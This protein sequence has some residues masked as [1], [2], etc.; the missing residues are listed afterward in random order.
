MTITRN[1]L[2]IFKPELLGDSP[3]AGGQRTKNAVESGQ[4][5]E[6]FRAISDIDHSQSSVD[7]VKCYPALDTADTSVLLNGHIFI[8]QKPTDELVSMLIAESSDLDDADRMTDMVEILESSV[9][10]GQLIRNRLIG[11]LAGQDSFP[12]SY[13]QTIYQFNGKEYYETLTLQQ[14]QT[15]VISVEYEGNEDA[16]WPRFEHFC[17]VQETVSG[18]KGGAVRFKPEIPYDTPNYDVVI[19]GESGCTKLRYT[20]ENDGIKFHGVSALTAPSDSNEL[21][22]ENTVVELLPK[23]R[24][25]AVSGGNTLPGVEDNDNTASS[26]TEVLPSMVYK[27]IYVPSVAGQTT[28]IFE[29]PDLLKDTWLDDNGIQSVKYN[30]GYAQNASVN[31]VGTTVTVTFSGTA[32]SGNQSVGLSY[33]SVQKWGVWETPA[34]FPADHILVLGKA[35]GAI[36]FADGSYGTSEIRTQDYPRPTDVTAIPILETN[37]N[38][39]GTINAVT[40][41]VTKEPDFR[42]DFSIVLGSLLQKTEPGEVVTPGD[43]SVVF[44]LDSDSP[45]LDTLYIQV[46]TTNDV[47]LSASSDANGVITGNGITGSVDGNI[48]SLSFSSPVW[49]STLTYDLTE[50]VTLSPPP[51]L[52]GLNPLRIKN[53]GVVNAFSAWTNVSVQ[54]TQTQLVN[55]PAAAQTYNVRANARFVDITDATGASLWTLTDDN[56][57]VDKAAGVVTINSDFSGFTAPYLLTDS[58]GELGLVVDVQQD[59][60]VLAS[61]LSQSYPAGSNVS[62]VQDLGDLQARVGSVRDMSSWSDNW[63]LDGTPATASLNVVDF[64]IEVINNTAINEDWVLIFT[65]PTAFRCVGKRLGQIETGDTLNDFTPINPLTLAPYFVIRQGAFG[66][67]WNTGEAVRFATYASSKPAMLLRT[68]Q[69]GHSQITTDRATLAFRG[70]ES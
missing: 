49:L 60:L 50:T 5:N 42:G 62:S 43:T 19:N 46:A 20:S 65:S 4:L 7:I 57:S 26:S 51:E 22:V 69:S 18:G 44:P 24:T 40:G 33:L 70:N 63:D 31:I 54:H 3:D 37:N 27:N 66:G 11:L 30:G 28:Y 16:N 53:S 47:L 17:E 45:I 38:R 21:S 58:I 64:P 6:L 34:A 68:V 35:F 61:P 36:T 9:R 29:V 32:P 15:I 56:Y 10:A 39:V 23:V 55:N 59:K 13:L 14:G 48:V 1:N 8:S 25:T 67:G 52:Y 41:V 12:R 2:A